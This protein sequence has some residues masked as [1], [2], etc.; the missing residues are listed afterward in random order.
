MLFSLDFDM[1]AA[2]VNLDKEDPTS[3]VKYAEIFI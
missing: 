2:V 3:L 1:K